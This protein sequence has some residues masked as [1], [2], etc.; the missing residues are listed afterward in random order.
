MTRSMPTPQ[1][2]YT[3]LKTSTSEIAPDPV[4]G[5]GT[6]AVSGDTPFYSTLVSDVPVTSTGSEDAPGVPGDTVVITEVDQWRNGDGPQDTLLVGF[7]RDTENYSMMWVGHKDN[8]IGFDTVSDGV[9]RPNSGN[10]NVPV[11]VES[12]DR[13]AVV[14]SGNFMTGYVER[15]GVW[16]RVHTAPA[17][18]HDNLRDPEVRAQYRYAVGLRGTEG[19]LRIGEFTAAQRSSDVVS[20]TPEPSPTPTATTSSSPT[21]TITASPQPTPTATT[22]PTTPAPS[23][24]RPQHQVEA[25][26]GV[27]GFH[28]IN[29]RYWYT[30][31][32]PYSQTIRCRTEIWSTQVQYQGGRFVKDNGWHF[33]NLTYLPKMTRAQWGNNPLANS[34]AFTSAGRQWRTECDTAATGRGGCRSHIRSDQVIATKNADGTWAYKLGKEWVF[35]NMVIFAR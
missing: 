28:V 24:S 31:C 5:S 9:L 18:G 21:P 26:Y 33:N 20:P 6:L 35:N 13:I 7:V 30:T 4:V 19:T 11:V 23:P 34:G 10:G 27:P 12:G 8:R 3:V 2:Q 22:K 14:L 25:P 17:N 15:N 29:D 16:H 1:K 32:E